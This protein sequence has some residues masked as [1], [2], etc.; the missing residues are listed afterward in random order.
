MLGVPSDGEGPEPG[1]L[2]NFGR[3]K[4]LYLMPNHSNPTGTSIGAR[5]RQELVEWS[6]ATGTPIVEDDYAADLELD[7][8]AAPPAMRALDGDVLYLSTFSKKL[9]PALR[10]GLLLCPPPLAP[11]LVPLA[12][13]A[14]LGPS[15]LLQHAL[16]EFLERGYLAAHLNRIRASYRERRDA[17]AEALRAH[18]PD[19]IGFDVPPRGTSLWLRLP[20]ELDGDLVFEEARRRGVLVSPG[21]LHRADRSGRSPAGIRVLYCYEPVP[22][23]VEGARRLGAAIDALAAHR[24]RPSPEPVGVV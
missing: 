23:L 20:D 2:G 7:G 8:A 4:A 22:R 14:S 3:A 17:L 24:H 13:A 6:R 18:L 16:A 5:R 10:I 11:H 1:R 19:A 15:G 12:H 21:S 9:I